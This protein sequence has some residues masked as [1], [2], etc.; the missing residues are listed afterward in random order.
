MAE[1]RILVL[2]LSMMKFTFAGQAIITAA[3]AVWILTV[4]DVKDG[5][6]AHKKSK[7]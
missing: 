2:I 1:E 5:F 3:I 4:T 6:T 7:N